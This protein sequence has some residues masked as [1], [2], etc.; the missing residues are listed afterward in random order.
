MRKGLSALA[1]TVALAAVAAAGAPARGAVVE[2]RVDSSVGPTVLFEGSVSTEPHPVDGGDG[3]G[4]HPC[5]GSIGAAPAA[6]ATGA[7]DDAMRGAGIPWR[8]NWNPDFHDFFVDAIGAFASQAP[9]RYWSLTVN[10]RFAGGGCLT[11]VQSGDTIR[12]SYGSLFA[13][14]TGAGGEGETAAGGGGGGTGGGGGSV[15]TS[16]DGP[17]A[18]RLR[19]LAA[20][21]ARFLRRDRGGVGAD[22]ARLTLALRRR[23]DAR[24]GGLG[25]YSTQTSN[26]VA[27]AAA[28]L[29]GKRLGDRRADGSIGGEVGATALAVQALAPRRPA[30]ALRAAAWLASVQGADGGFGYRPGVPADVDSAGLATWALASAGATNVNPAGTPRDAMDE[31]ARRGGG[32]VAAAQNADGGFP[33]LPGGA[34]NSQSTG[35]AL[36]ALRVSGVGP[37]THSSAG[38]TALDYLASLGRH[39]G[40]IGYADGASPTPVW[41]TAQALLGLTSRQRLLGFSGRR[42]DARNSLPG[43]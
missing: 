20:R 9:D 40:S 3:S 19:A 15:P 5:S 17:P 34:S 2:L 32:F 14:G 18:S 7:L 13:P 25:R 43:P 24:V 29:L 16:A 1:A 30:A 38:R 4:P 11:T 33:S 27:A 21:A 10:G 22:W 42:S 41:T 31:A 37:R 8:G 36:V 39:D 23:P 12:F 26:S 6:T 35:L 28:G